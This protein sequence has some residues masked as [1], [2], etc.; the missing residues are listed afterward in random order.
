M[1]GTPVIDG[2]IYIGSDNVILIDGLK[3]SR[4]GAFVN[5]AVVGVTLKDHNGTELTGDTWPSVG[6]YQTGSDGDYQ[7]PIAAAVSVS[8]GQVVEAVVTAVSGGLTL[9]WNLRLKA[10]LRTS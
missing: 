10:N 2:T 1:P 8:V 6:S 3:N 7:I 5:D 9:T 4:T